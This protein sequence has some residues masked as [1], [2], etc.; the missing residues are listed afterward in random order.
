MFLAPI[1]LIFDHF[2]VGFVDPGGQISPK[3][4]LNDYYILCSIDLH[5]KTVT[6]CDLFMFKVLKIQIFHRIFTQKSEF[7]LKNP[8]FQFFMVLTDKNA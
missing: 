5:K 7:S 3:L 2:F 4:I 6:Q 8:H 1:L